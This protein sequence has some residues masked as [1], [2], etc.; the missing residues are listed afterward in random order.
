MNKASVSTATSQK[1]EVSTSSVTLSNGQ[2]GHIAFYPKD[3]SSLPVVVTE[4]GLEVNLNLKKDFTILHYST[5]R[6]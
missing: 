5:S 2:K 4:D 1:G 6:E 3:F